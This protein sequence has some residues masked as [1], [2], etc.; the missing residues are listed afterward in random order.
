MAQVALMLSA[1]AAVA[2]VGAGALYLF[3]RYKIARKRETLNVGV[4]MVYALC[5]GPVR[6]L[7]V[8]G[9]MLAASAMVVSLLGS[10]H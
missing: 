5:V 1:L 10:M 9:C 2:L 6:T 3:A 7:L 8:A 4:A